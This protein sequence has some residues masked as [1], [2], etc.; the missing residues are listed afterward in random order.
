MTGTIMQEKAF[1][2]NL[3][4]Y[5][6]ICQIYLQEYNVKCWLK[7]KLLWKSLTSCCLKGIWTNLSKT[8]KIGV[9][10]IPQSSCI[11]KRHTHSD[12]TESF[13]CDAYAPLE[14]IYYAP[15][16]SSVTSDCSGVW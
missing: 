12:Y 14:N 4:E 6:Y 15:W 8:D 13:Q 11:D 5:T 1:L 16:Y 9:L 3:Q 2:P 10:N 7:Q